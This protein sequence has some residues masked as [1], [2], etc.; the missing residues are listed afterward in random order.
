M[1]CREQT[2]VASDK[3][4]MAGRALQ[5]RGAT[6][7]VACPDNDT[8]AHTMTSL[9]AGFRPADGAWTVSAPPVTGREFVPHVAALLNVVE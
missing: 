2:K 7:V 6:V 9:A 5:A 1:V 3:S 4:S 8:C